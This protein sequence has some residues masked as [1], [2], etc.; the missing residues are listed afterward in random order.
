MVSKEISDYFAKLVEPLVTAQRYEEMFGKL[1]EEIIEK[2]EE[3]FTA[4][5]KNSG[6]G[7]KSWSSRKKKIENL[8]I[9]C[10][11]N[12]QYSRQYCL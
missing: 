9:K 12:E 10:N 4:Q 2:I 1:K 6:L 3:K 5:N 7:G 8:N 11:S